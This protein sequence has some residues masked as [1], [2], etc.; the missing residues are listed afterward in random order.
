MNFSKGILERRVQTYR[1][2]KKLLKPIAL[3]TPTLLELAP[4]REIR[5][6]LFD[7]NHCVGAVMFLIEDEGNAIL[8]TGD[9]RS[10]KWW[11][12]SLSRNPVLLPYVASSDLLPLKQLDTIYLDTTF[13]SKLDP[14][15]QFPS[16]AS[17]TMELLRQVAK[18]PPD[19]LFYLDAWTFGYEDVWQALST[20]LGTQI[21]V[22]DYRHS[23]YT[24]LLYSK[25]LRSPEAFKLIG[26]NCGNHFQKG[27]LSTEQSR[28]HSCEKGTG[29]SIWNKSEHTWIVP[30][31]NNT[32]DF[33]GFVRIAPIISRYKGKQH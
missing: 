22:D 15:V 4:G 17:G 26:S 12:N 23:L 30:D 13:A 33:L 14:Y 20:F 19:T 27:C 32:D 28:V 16:K 6:T 8:Y 2:L 11:I 3:E 5:V 1:H 7:A 21:H 31:M 10:E 25:D 18:Y 29:C 9:I 24:S